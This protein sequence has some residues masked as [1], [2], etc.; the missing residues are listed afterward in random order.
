[1]LSGNVR[2]LSRWLFVIVGLSVLSESI[3]SI[4]LD[5][6]PCVAAMT[7]VLVEVRFINIYG[8]HLDRKKTQGV[9]LSF[10]IVEAT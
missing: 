4:N 9:H 2:G 8:Y 1:M 6:C 7:E 5:Y 3:W 10:Q